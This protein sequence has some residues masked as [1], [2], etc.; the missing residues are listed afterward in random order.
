MNYFIVNEN[1]TRIYLLIYLIT[2]LPLLRKG[3]VV[4]VSGDSSIC[5]M[6]LP[7][8]IIIISEFESILIQTRKN[9][10]TPQEG[11]YFPPFLFFFI[12]IIDEVLE[13][14]DVVCVHVEFNGIWCTS[15]PEMNLNP[16]T[17]LVNV[18]EPMEDSRSE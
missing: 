17:I 3:K 14:G 13:G 12:A 16:F 7:E 9:L 5:K 1:K 2:L 4:P 6:M 11:V 18:F 8:I 15:R 10:Q